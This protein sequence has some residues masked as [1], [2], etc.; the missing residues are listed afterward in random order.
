MTD[1]K[2][3]KLPG[4]I[5]SSL[6][7]FYLHSFVQRSVHQSV[8]RQEESANGVEEGIAILTVPVEPETK[9]Q[10]NESQPHLEGGTENILCHGGSV[11]GT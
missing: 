9:R 11:S 10:S 8:E 2:Q 7:Y 5:N 1:I 4:N 3:V 6:S